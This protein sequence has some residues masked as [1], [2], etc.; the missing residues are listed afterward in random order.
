MLRHKV[1]PGITGWAQ[2]NGLRGETETLDK[3]RARIQYDIDTMRN[4]SLLF[5]LMIIGKTL[6]GVGR[7][8][9]AY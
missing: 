8:Q 1:K 4:G 2:V 9:S 3:M 7:G 6:A 5:D